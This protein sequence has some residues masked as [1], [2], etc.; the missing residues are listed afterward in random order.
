MGRFGAE[1][2]LAAAQARGR[3]TGGKLRVLTHCNTGSLATAAFGTALGVVRTLHLQGQ[4]E[5]A[6]CTGAGWA[7]LAA[8]ECRW[9]GLAAL[10][11]QALLCLVQVGD[12]PHAKGSGVCRMPALL[13]VHMLD[14]CALELRFRDALGPGVLRRGAARVWS[15]GL[16]MRVGCYFKDDRA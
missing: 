10:A 9:R 13:A 7:G 15:L 6:Y 12:V 4:L 16:G 1:A 11:A 2:M 5:H 14:R 3:A 8:A